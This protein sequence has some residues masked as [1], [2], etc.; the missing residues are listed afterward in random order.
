MRH[1]SEGCSLRITLVSILILGSSLLFWSPHSVFAQTLP[2]TLDP[3]GR[4]AEPPPLQ[5]IPGPRPIPPGSVLPVQPESSVGSEASLLKFHVNEI[6]VKGGT[7]LTPEEIAKV[8]RPYLKREMTTEVLEEL[9]QTFTSFYAG[10]GYINSGAYVP[11]QDVSDG[12]LEIYMVEG[13]LTDIE[14]QGAE[15]FLP[16]YF[17]QRINLIIGPPLNIN[18]LRERLQMFLEDDRIKRLNSELQPGLRVGEAVLKVQVEEASPYQVFTEFN[19]FQSA[20]VGAEQGLGTFVHRNVFGLGDVFQFTFGRSEGVSPLIDFGYSV[21]F[22]PWDTTLILN[23]RK[24]EFDVVQQP[25]NVLDISSSTNVYS[26]TLR[27]P[28]YRRLGQEFALFISGEYLVNIVKAFDPPTPFNLVVGANNG[29]A[30]VAA[31]RFGQDWISRTAGQVIALRS[32]FSVGVDVLDATPNPGN[33]RLPSSQFFGWRGQGQWVQR[34]L[35]PLGV[36][37][38]VRSDLQLASRP[39]FPQEAYPV[40]GRFTVRGYPE[41]TVVRDNA[42]IFSLETRIPLFQQVLGKNY[43]QLAP[44]F[45]LGRGWQAKP[46]PT[47]FSSA[48]SPTKTL[49]SV[50]VGLRAGVPELVDFNIYWGQQLNHVPDRGNTLQDNGLHMQFIWQVW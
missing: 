14:I 4:S 27:Q 49:A 42:F 45:D 36:L 9:R 44:F 31:I 11:D 37:V 5:Q 2:P 21:P 47:G 28:V 12:V 20:S 1:W 39:L 25:F 46:R 33:D 18:P 48:L 15:S 13:I 38:I 41:N 3:S 17:E 50:G 34:L 35:D 7:V 16:S 30:N 43:V 8:V 32:L 19:N 26:I 10:R 29:V 22:T 23:F 24:N 6:Q 40:G